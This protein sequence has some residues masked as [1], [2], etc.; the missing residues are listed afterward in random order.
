MNNPITKHLQHGGTFTLLPSKCAEQVSYTYAYGPPG[1]HGLRRNPYTLWSAVFASIGGL[2]FG[3]DQGVI[4]NVLVMEDF[5]RRFPV[6]AW[7]VGVMSESLFSISVNV[8]VDVYVIDSAAM[9]E[10]GALV[11]T[12]VAGTFTDRY[13]RQHS[14]FVSCGKSPYNQTIR[15]ALKIAHVRLTL[16]CVHPTQ[17]NYSDIHPRLYP[18]NFRSLPHTPHSGSRHWW[19]RHRC[20]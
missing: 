4:A 1:L 17:L 5:R 7:E 12:L 18:P 3:Y 11:G 6:G 8:E 13:S 14:I 19:H 10:L 16:H 2:S 20:P 9:L 15:R